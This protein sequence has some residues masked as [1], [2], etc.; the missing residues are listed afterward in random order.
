MPE[1]I[2]EHLVAWSKSLD[3]AANCFNPPGYI[4][5][6]NCSFG[7]EQ[8]LAHEANQED[9]GGQQMPVSCIDGSRV[10]FYQ[11]LIIFD[12]GLVHLFEMEHIGRSV[13]S[14]DHGFHYEYPFLLSSIN[15]H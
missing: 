1:N 8:P 11:D 7:F 13:L 15:V 6:K 10:D 3:V 14:V 2:A 5:S 9:I 4:S 12:R